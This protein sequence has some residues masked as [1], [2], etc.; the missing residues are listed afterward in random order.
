MTVCSC[1]RGGALDRGPATSTKPERECRGL[2][3]RVTRPAPGAAGSGTSTGLARS[4]AFARYR[5]GPRSA[6]AAFS[7]GIAFGLPSFVD[8][9][10]SL[11]IGDVL[12]VMART[13]RRWGRREKVHDPLKTTPTGLYSITSRASSVGGMVRPSAVAA[14]RLMTSSNLA[15]CCTGRSAAFSPLR[16]RPA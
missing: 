4:T 5:T 11:E 6:F 8:R 14:F 13:E 10:A 15:A 7:I 12:K 3:L 9:R 1:V 2:R 16:M